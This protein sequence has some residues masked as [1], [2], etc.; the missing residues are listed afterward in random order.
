MDRTTLTAALMPLKRRR[1][2]GVIPDPADT[3]ACLLT[4][5]RT[6]RTLLA[7]AVPIWE[8]THARLDTLLGG[9]NLRSKLRALS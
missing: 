9:N 7:R 2:V 3:R 1:L 4:L 5:T 6:G 8:R